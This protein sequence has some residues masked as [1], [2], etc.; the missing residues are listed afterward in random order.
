MALARAHRLVD[1]LV[2]ARPDSQKAARD[3]L[4]FLAK[5]EAMVEEERTA[6]HAPAAETQEADVTQE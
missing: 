5:Y 6:L 3:T 2:R 1:R 4:D